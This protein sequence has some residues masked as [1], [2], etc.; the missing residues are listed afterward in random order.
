MT[1]VTNPGELDVNSFESLT[2]LWE[3]RRAGHGAFLAADGFECIAWLLLIPPVQGLAI[4]LGGARR[5]GTSLFTACFTLAAVVSIVDFL[6]MAGTITVANS[7][8]TFLANSSLTEMQNLELVFR[9]ARSRTLWLASLDYLFLTIGLVSVAYL[10]VLHREHGLKRSWVVCTCVLSALTFIG[11]IAAVSR[12]IEY[13][14]LMGVVLRRINGLYFVMVLS[15][16]L[17]LWLTWLGTQ[18]EANDGK[19]FGFSQFGG[20][21]RAKVEAGAE[22]VRPEVGISNVA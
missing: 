20:A 19:E 7:F 1:S 2:G 9:M 16:F 11:F 15:L 14:T 4:M 22:M 10:S 13:G 6:S 5:S 3:G 21:P 17:P 18:L 12:A 8:S